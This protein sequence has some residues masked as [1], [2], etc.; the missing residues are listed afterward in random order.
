MTAPNAG[1]D[2]VSSDFRAWLPQ[3]KI[4]AILTGRSSDTSFDAD[5]DLILTVPAANA[6][7]SFLFT[8]YVSSAANA[9]GDMK[10]QIAWDIPT[11]TGSCGCNT[12]ST[13][14]ASGFTPT[15]M[16]LGPTNRLDTSSPIG[17]MTWGCSTSGTLVLITG[18]LTVGDTVGDIWL[19]WAQNSSN[20]NESRVL[21]GST[22]ELWQTFMQ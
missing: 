14:L 11:A 15:E 17:G 12:A 16:V 9:A 22:F 2:I 4:K 21:E 18:H 5:P 13:A 1:E 10:A 20:A 8:L 7:Y 19:E 6:D 3:K